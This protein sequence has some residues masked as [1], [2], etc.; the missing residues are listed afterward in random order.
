MSF[1]LYRN[2]NVTS[3]VSSE[4]LIVFFLL[5]GSASAIVA[6]FNPAPFRGRPN[7]TFQAWDFLT[8]TDRA[9]P[10]AGW[11]NP[12]GSPFTHILGDIPYILKLTDFLAGS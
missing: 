6:D 11:I 9:V 4:I 3:E 8:K 7:T 1:W 2:K 10:E 5:V 12:F